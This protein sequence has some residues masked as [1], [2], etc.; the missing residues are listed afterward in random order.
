MISQEEIFKIYNHKSPRLEEGKERS[1]SPMNR[2]RSTFCG[3]N[4]CLVS[5]NEKTML[6]L[7]FQ[8]IIQ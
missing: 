6:S 1:Y 5:K 8:E 2:R 7:K 3:F 4:L